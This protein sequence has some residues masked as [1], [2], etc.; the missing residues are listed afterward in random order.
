MKYFIVFISLLPALAYA[1]TVYSENLTVQGNTCIGFD[2][3]NDQ[4]F[5]ATPLELKEN[6]LRIRLR[7]TGAPTATVTVRGDDYYLSSDQMGGSWNLNANESGNG[8]IDYFSIEQATDSP[9]PRLSDGTAIN[10]TCYF[11]GTT[12][13]ISG[14]ANADI[15]D[16][17]VDGTIPQGEPWETQYCEN[18]SEPIVRNGLR[19][20]PGATDSSGGVALGFGADS[21]EAAVSVGNANKLRRLANLAQALNGSDVL[22]VAQMDTYGDQHALLDELNATL[23]RVE[24]R[25]DVLENPSG[26]GGSLP[27]TLLI[28][29]TLL[30]ATRRRH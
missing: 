26:N 28:T 29:L 13:P 4:T 12:T 11:A 18:V 21:R 8:G 5:S 24:R 10:Y 19:F 6:N 7:D 2:C 15:M 9:V 17:F 30:L 14:E 20:T 3:A 22:T 23:D 16:V 27:A 1:D 25:L